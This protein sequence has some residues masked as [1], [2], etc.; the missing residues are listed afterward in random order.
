MWAR[1]HQKGFT[2]V[3]LLIVIVVIGILAAITIV[4]YNGLQARSRDSIRKADLASINKA[5]RLFYAENGNYPMASGWCTQ[6]S[7]PSYA[8]S[9]KTEMAP[10]ISNIPSDPA[11]G[12]TNQDY[13]YRNI[14]DQSYELYAELEQSDENSYTSGSCSSIGGVL[15]LYDYKVQ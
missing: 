13:F 7:N 15:N 11:Y 9:F 14:N 5:I 4:A 3:E 6:M 8:A 2:I 1:Q 10:Y 12:I